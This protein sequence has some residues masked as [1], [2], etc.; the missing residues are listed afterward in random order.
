MS[1]LAEIL[2]GLYRRRAHGIK[3][4]LGRIEA[5]L[6]RLGNPERDIAAVHVAGTN[7][8]GSV[9][10]MVESVF[11]AA[12]YRTGL[13]TS[14]H[15]V[16]L[17]ERMR[18]ASECI[19]NQELVD[20][21]ELINPH[22]DAVASA[23]GEVTFFEFTT[24]LAFEHFR[25]KEARLV[26]LETGM[27]GRLDATNVVQ[28]LV[29]AITR[30][31]VE[32]TEYLGPDVE[33]IAAEKCGV[34]K[35]GRPVICG[36]MPEEAMAVVMRTAK[37]REAKVI[38]ANEAVS[39]HRLSQDL[40]GQKVRI[41]SEGC[42][43]PALML[44]L[45]GVHQ[46]ENCATAVATLEEVQEAG[47]LRIEEDAYAK[48]LAC[49]EWQGRCQVLS[50]DPPIILDGAH[51]PVAAEA[52]GRALKDIAGGRDVG[53]VLGMCNDKDVRGFL[54][55]LSRLVK[56]CWPVALQNDRGMT[57]SELAREAGRMGWGA[58]EAPLSEALAA[59]ERWA[60]ESDA[61]ICICGSLYL[62]GEVLSLRDRL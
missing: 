42:D 6:A 32:H 24:A 53:L 48:G 41:G 12:G 23:H 43:Y 49:V 11:R 15:L 54:R 4:G 3:P 62:V 1:E 8:K 60:R 17:N 37:Q 34:I 39:V 14:P 16:R 61:L 35:P 19:E 58:T 50:V 7:G 33:S 26:I 9:C 57:S 36:E 10:A 38:L 21:I 18:V 2:A 52:L 51:N 46:L 5:L 40:G 28:P 31:S 59:S 45:L 22:A 55:P 47:K 56:Q 13:Y 44:P 30:I 20:L 29:S 27:G 25:R